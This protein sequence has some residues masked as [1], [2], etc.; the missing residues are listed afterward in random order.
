MAPFCIMAISKRNPNYIPF[1]DM[2]VFNADLLDWSVMS[3]A[4]IIYD[5]QMRRISG[6]SLLM[7]RLQW[8]QTIWDTGNRFIQRMIRWIWLSPW[9]RRVILRV[10]MEDRKIKI[11][12]MQLRYL[13]WG[14]NTSVI[15]TMRWWDVCPQNCLCQLPIITELMIFD[16]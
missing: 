9:S 8:R 13:L 10:S 6:R 2:L 4:M 11:E 1:L 16:S 3:G 5:E 7:N 15:S 14:M 12:A